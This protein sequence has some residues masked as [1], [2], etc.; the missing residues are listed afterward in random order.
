MRTR[1]VLCP[2]D[3]SE[4]ASHALKYAIEMANLYHVNIRLLHVMSEGNRLHHYGTVLEKSSDLEHKHVIPLRQ[5]TT[6]LAG[7]IAEYLDEG[8]KVI[9]VI[10]RGDVVAQIIEESVEQQVGMIVI[11]S[12]GYKGISHLLNPNVSEV[13]SNKAHCPVLVVK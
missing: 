8:L 13:I 5:K 9:P 4:T 6:Q 3:F 12:H 2:T 11:G 1:Q 10:R 7:E